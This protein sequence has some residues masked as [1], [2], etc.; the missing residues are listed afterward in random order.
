MSE[1]TKICRSPQLTYRISQVTKNGNTKKIIQ[2]PK[3]RKFPGD[4][5]KLHNNERQS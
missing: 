2:F 5:M 4:I 1:Y 3:K